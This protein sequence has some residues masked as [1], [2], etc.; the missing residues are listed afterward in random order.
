VNKI[1]KTCLALL[2]VLLFGT[3]YSYADG[4]ILD[5]PSNRLPKDLQQQVEKAGGALL[6]SWDFLGLAVADFPDESTARSL[7]KSGF[8]VMPDLY[9]NWLPDERGVEVT[10]L[11]DDETYYGYQWHLPLMQAD[12]AWMEGYTG[13]GV[14]VA[15]L[16]SGIYYP[17][18]DLAANIDF[19]SS[20]TFVPGTTDFLDD[21][22]H[23]THVA[24]II[25][26]ADNGWGTIGV[27]PHATL[28]GVKVMN[29]SGSGSF[30]WIMAGIVHAVTHDADI[31]NMSLRGILLKGRD[32]A[33]LWA[34]LNKLVNWAASHDVLVVSAAGNDEFNFNHS[35]NLVVIPAEAGNS[36]AVSATGPTDLPAPYTNYGTSLV[37]VAAPGGDF[38]ISSPLGGVFSTYFTPP[39][40]SGYL[41]AWMSG[42]SMAAPN[43]C[44]VAALIIEKYGR[45]SVGRLKTILAN[46]ADDLGKPGTD[47]FYGRGR[48]NAYRAVTRK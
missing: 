8:K 45:M 32:S 41:F 39:G 36:L 6:L 38:S 19:S 18:P 3:A 48:V 14:R 9:I 33:M 30:S 10:N 20:A 35:R 42:T 4:W 46:S 1:T 13:Q 29:A 2:L 43:A 7:E 47:D 12:L 37:W 25:A 44:G 23:G 17:H 5:S 40:Y 22:G 21:N 34:T 15:V 31:I 27:A 11:E 16:D 28:I 24:G 26:A